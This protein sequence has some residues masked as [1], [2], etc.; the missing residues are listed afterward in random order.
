[1]TAQETNRGTGRYSEP[2]EKL[3]RDGTEGLSGQGKRNAMR[4]ARTKQ[5]K[6]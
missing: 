2:R 4:D 6:K 1:M 3:R 5:G